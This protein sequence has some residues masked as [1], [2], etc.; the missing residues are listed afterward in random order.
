M[1]GSGMVDIHYDLSGG[2]SNVGGAKSNPPIPERIRV[3]RARYYR[4]IN[5][6]RSGPTET[7]RT[8]HSMVFSIS[9]I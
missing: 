1:D 8:G 9:R 7:K 6:S 3:L 4:T 5:A 2:V